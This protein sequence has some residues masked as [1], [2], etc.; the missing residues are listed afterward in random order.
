MEEIVN[1][2]AKSDIVTLNL[3]D[4]YEQ[5]DRVL[6][7]IKDQ[8]YQGIALKEKDFREYIRTTNWSDYKD[9]YVAIHCSV[10][11]IIPTWAYMLLASSLEPYA[12][13]F[14]YGDLNDMERS[15][16]QTRLSSEDWEQ[17]RGRKIIIKGCGHLPI[18]EF[19]YVE[20][21][22]LLRPL[23]SSIMYGEPCSTVP[24]Y[25]QPKEQ[26]EK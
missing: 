11:A 20:L 6:I 24:I 15:L 1:R 17:Y 7:D 10:D 2:V 18:P 25:K 21:T 5:G 4:F 26:A 16:F 13:M 8:L 9:K 3:E 22:R 12:K 23:A 19:A 14:F